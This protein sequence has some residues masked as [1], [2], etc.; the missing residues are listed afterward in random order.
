[1]A[2]TYTREHIETMV[3][4]ALVQ[5]VKLPPEKFSPAAKIREDLGIDSL[6]VVELMFDIEKRFE[7]TIPDED[8]LRIVTVNDLINYLIKKLQT[9]EAGA[10]GPSAPSA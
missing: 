7:M 4:E 3:R 6:D 1:M 9:N 8:L 2:A 10:P 5:Q